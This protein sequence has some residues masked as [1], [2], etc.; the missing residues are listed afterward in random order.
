MK[1]IA[2]FTQQ[3]QIL[4]LFLFIEYNIIHNIIDA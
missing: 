4:L 1:F 3:F 2:L